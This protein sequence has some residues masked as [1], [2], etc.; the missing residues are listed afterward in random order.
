MAISE[1][2]G[3][4][5]IAS[6]KTIGRALA[7]PTPLVFIVLLAMLPSPRAKLNSVAFLAG[8]L[9]RLL[10]LGGVIFAMGGWGRHR[11]GLCLL[12]LAC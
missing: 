9:T 11:C 7:H 2:Q 1:P 3:F 6:E 4:P 5:S 12:Q 10:M 8:W